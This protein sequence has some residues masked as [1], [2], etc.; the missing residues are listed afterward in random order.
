MHKY[1]PVIEISS[2]EDQRFSASFSFPQTIFTTV[3]AYQ[4]QQVSVL[5]AVLGLL[6]NKAPIQITK[7]KIASNPFAKGFRESTRPRDCS[8]WGLVGPGGGV[9]PVLLPPLH[10]LLGLQLYHY[11]QY[12][13]EKY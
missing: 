11:N 5:S 4:N 10:P 9:L 12:A 1:Q 13:G 2:R 6:T 8:V 7:L 3:T